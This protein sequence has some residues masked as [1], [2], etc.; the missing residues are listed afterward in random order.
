M[1]AMAVEAADTSAHATGDYYQVWYCIS[2]VV[3]AIDQ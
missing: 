1:A 3:G 2:G